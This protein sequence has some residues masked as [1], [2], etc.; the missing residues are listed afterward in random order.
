MN[1]LKPRERGWTAGEKACEG[2]LTSHNQTG[3]YPKLTLN[4]IL[5][6]YHPFHIT[7]AKR[8]NKKTLLNIQKN[9]KLTYSHII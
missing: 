8:T 5:Q 3:T 6:T 7:N 4:M 9:K 2:S 1:T